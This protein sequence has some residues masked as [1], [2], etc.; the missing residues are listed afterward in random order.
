[1]CCSILDTNSNKKQK[2]HTQILVLNERVFIQGESSYFIQ[3]NTPT[4]TLSIESNTKRVAS[5]V[6]D[7]KNKTPLY[8]LTHFRTH[9]RSL[10]LALNARQSPQNLCHPL[11]LARLA[12]GVCCGCVGVIIYQSP[13]C[14][15]CVYL[16]C[17]CCAAPNT[18]LY[19]TI[20]PYTS[21]HKY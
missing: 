15:V 20:I 8:M 21:I 7:K 16:L 14:F 12:A 11:A 17:V 2:T 5:S 10:A 1:M 9:S 6:L 19:H 13:E 3:I 18:M 4:Q